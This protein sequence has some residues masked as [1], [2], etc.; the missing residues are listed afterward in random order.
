MHT[1]PEVKEVV[2]EVVN[3]EEVKELAKNVEN[4]VGKVLG[5]ATP[6]VAHDFEDDS[7]NVPETT[8][9]QKNEPVVSTPTVTVDTPDV[10][11]G[12]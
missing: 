4:T 2:A 8:E 5:E 10:Q 1:I 6:L 12:M 3:S 9:V 11:P 7:M